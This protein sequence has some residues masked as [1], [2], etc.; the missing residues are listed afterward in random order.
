[1]EICLEI[2]ERLAQ[3]G[4]NHGFGSDSKQWRTV[5]KSLLTLEPMPEIG[6]I[7]TQQNL[8]MLDQRHLRRQVVT[9]QHLN[10][11]SVI[12]KTDVISTTVITR[13]EQPDGIHS[14]PLQE[15]HS[16]DGIA[17]P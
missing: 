9:L 14:G 7:V 16:G 2:I 17:G 12:P 11:V 4:T 6:H 5:T 10:V 8:S 13:T 3:T 1:M 15:Q